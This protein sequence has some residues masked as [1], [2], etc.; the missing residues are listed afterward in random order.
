MKY[1]RK[2]ETVDGVDITVKPNVVLVAD[3][4][5]V[6]YNV[7]KGIFIQ[8]TDGT[9]YT[10]EEWTAG[11]FTSDLANGVA[12][13]DVAC[14]FVI[15]K[16]DDDAGAIV[17]GSNTSSAISGVMLTSDEETAKTDYAGDSNTELIAATRGAA[18]ECAN[19]AFP[20]GQKGYLPALGELAVAYAN[21]SSINAAMRLIEGSI[22]TGTYWSSTQHSANSAWFLEFN[23]GNINYVNKSYTIYNTF[24]RAFTTLS[25]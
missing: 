8:H 23:D 6:Y 25:L 4:G 16:A 9:L 14:S 5:N 22:L 20:N 3:T 10:T 12:V 19:Y 1:L 13:C 24:A 15:A 17:W 18:Y 2:F 21:K 11:S 7:T